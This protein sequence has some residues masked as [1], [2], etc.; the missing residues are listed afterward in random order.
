MP[1][2]LDRFTGGLL[3]AS[4]PWVPSLVVPDGDPRVSDFL[5]MPTTVLELDPFAQRGG[6]GKGGD[7]MPPRH[8]RVH[9]DQYDSM[10]QLERAHPACWMWS[11][12]TRS[13]EESARAVRTR[14]GALGPGQ[15]QH[16][17]GGA[18][19]LRIKET[20]S[21]LRA[22]GLTEMGRRGWKRVMDEMAADA[23]LYCL[24]TDHRLG[25]ES[26]HYAQGGHGYKAGQQWVAR[27]YGAYWHH[28]MTPLHTQRMLAKLGMYSGDLDGD[29]G[30]LTR[31]GILTFQR[32]WRLKRTARADIWTRK[33][34]AFLTAVEI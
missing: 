27:T 7:Y 8:R 19:D 3:D 23:G 20:R 31:E 11:D 12:V 26:W 28:Q 5:E 22:A 14:R 1:D 25:H 10:W 33:M 16:N 32:A 15:S 21:R 18:S 4:S 17:W 29:H 6:Y 2:W 24:R 9:P 34:L 30:P 13:A